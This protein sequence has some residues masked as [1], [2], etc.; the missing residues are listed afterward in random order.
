M[1]VLLSWR[2]P[3]GVTWSQPDDWAVGGLD[4][5]DAVQG[6]DDLAEWVGV[7]CGARAGGEFDR[8]RSQGRV[9]WRHLDRVDMVVT[10][11]AERGHR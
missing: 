4:L 11:D 6:D 2:S 1:P 3:D 8:H 10:E 7:P 5:T 9:G